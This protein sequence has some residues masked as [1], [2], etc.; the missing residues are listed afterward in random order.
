MHVQGKI[1]KYRAQ[2]KVESKLKELTL[3]LNT[4]TLALKLQANM[5]YVVILQSELSNPL[6]LIKPTPLPK[7][8]QDSMSNRKLLT[9]RQKVKAL[10]KCMGFKQFQDLLVVC[11][12]GNNFQ[13]L[14]KL[15]LAWVNCFDPS[16]MLFIMW[17][18]RKKTNTQ[19]TTDAS[20]WFFLLP[21]K[22]FEKTKMRGFPESS[23]SPIDIGNSFDTI[24]MK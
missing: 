11:M 23:H 20:A 14:R 16:I 6:Q 2:H 3:I 8:T 15:K 9:T 10:V 1:E 18:S 4:I 19:S 24:P 13:N 5:S 21:R 7:I 17:R 12:V 22:I